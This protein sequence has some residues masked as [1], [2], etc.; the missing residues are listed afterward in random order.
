MNFYQK[1]EG[2]CYNS[3]TLFLYQFISLFQPKGNLLDIGSGCGVLGLLLKRDFDIN[4]TQIEIQKEN[5]SFNQKNSQENN[6]ESNIICMDFLDFST[7][8]KYEFIVSNPPFYDS[9]I[10]STNKHLAISRYSEYLNLEALIKKTNSLLTPLGEFIFCYDARNFIKVVN[11]L[12]KYKFNI[13]DIQ[14]VYPTKEKIS[15]LVLIR[16]KKSSHAVLNVHSPVIVVKDNT[17]T[18]EALKVFKK[19][20][21]NSIKI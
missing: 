5:I 4:L 17:N 3:D 1:K 19:A 13:C 7:S 14:F 10:K 11:I 21:L 18:Q 2:Y 20:D 16:A 6:L 8:M 15:K 9:S 12:S